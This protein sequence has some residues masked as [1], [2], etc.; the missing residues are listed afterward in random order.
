MKTTMKQSLLLACELENILS[1]KDTVRIDFRAANLNTNLTKQLS[2]N[3]IEWRGEKILKTIGLFGA[4]AAGKSNIIR[5]IIF[6]CRTILDSHQFN[7]NKRVFDFVPFKFDNYPSKPTRFYINFV[8]DD[9]EY[10]YTYTLTQERI[11]SES[12]Y[13][14]PNQKRAKIFDRQNNEI[15]FGSK[16]I[17]RPKEVA[18]SLTPKNLFLSRASAM[19]R[20]LAQ[21]IYKFF[22]HEF[23]LDLVP[24]QGDQIEY[25]FKKYK[26][27]ILNAMTC[28]DSD[29]VDIILK[30]RKTIQPIPRMQINGEATIE[31]AQAEIIEFKTKHRQNPDIEFD[32]NNEE[33]EGTKRLFAILNVL[34]EFL[35]YGKAMLLDEY[36]RQ[37]HTR[38]ADFILN[39]IHASQESQLL[40]TSHNT[41]L[42]DVKRFRRDQIL[43]VGKREDG[44]TEVY[45]LSD[46]KDFRENMDAEKGYLQGRFDAVPYVQESME[47]L[48]SLLK[49]GL[50]E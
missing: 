20:P 16:V 40:F 27:L 22:M 30:K 14:Y 21:R 7:M 8:C 43:F 13:Y 41:N 34:I 35:H 25:F 2:D 15:T 42:I 45:A 33:S 29:I 47:E 46:F 36:D 5:A 44:S 49:G 26:Q 6:F 1:I 48:K 39:L 50:H 12:L 3:V 23:M 38:L 32:M 17:T 31:F 19:N 4:N 28:C 18:D 10:E 37:M 9:I 11:L 24:I